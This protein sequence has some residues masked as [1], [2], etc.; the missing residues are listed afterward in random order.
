MVGPKDG[1]KSAKR[2]STQQPPQQLGERTAQA[3]PDGASSAPQS[4]SDLVNNLVSMYTKKHRN[5][6]K[7]VVCSHSLLFLLHASLTCS[8]LTDLGSLY[9]FSIFDLLF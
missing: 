6:E 8:F 5:L 2:Q 9:I 4:A 7:R 1:A 3:Q